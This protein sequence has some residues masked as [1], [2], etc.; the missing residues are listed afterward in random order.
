MS[1]AFATGWSGRDEAQAPRPFP[2]L[3]QPAGV[4]GSSPG[5]PHLQGHLLPLL[6]VLGALRLFFWFFCGY[7]FCGGGS[8]LQGS[9]RPGGGF[10]AIISFLWC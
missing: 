3:S 6:A 4:Q 10:R 2:F 9:L 8:C 1:G 5:A 7:F